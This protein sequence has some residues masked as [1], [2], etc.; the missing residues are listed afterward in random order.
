M[1]PSQFAVKIKAQIRKMEG[2]GNTENGPMN[3]AERERERESERE[4][5]RER[6]RGRKRERERVC[7]CLYGSWGGASA[8]LSTQSLHIYTSEPVVKREQISPR[9][10]R[11]RE[12]ERA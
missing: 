3:G 7:V 11:E 2:W 4:R 9:K 1:K 8:F 10:Q 12:R 6:E 5:E